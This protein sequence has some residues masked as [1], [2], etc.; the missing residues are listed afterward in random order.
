MN[1]IYSSPVWPRSV[2]WWRSLSRH[3]T[4]RC[5][6]RNP[7]LLGSFAFDRCFFVIL[8]GSNAYFA[9]FHL[10]LIHQIWREHFQLFLCSQLPRLT[11]LSRSYPLEGWELCDYPLEESLNDDLPDRNSLPKYGNQPDNQRSVGEKGYPTNKVNEW[12][13]SPHGI[14]Y[15]IFM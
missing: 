5:V 13:G 8:D 7:D 10:A 15:C 6:R 9:G 3:H 12:N 1:F 11:R 2:M 4:P 14:T